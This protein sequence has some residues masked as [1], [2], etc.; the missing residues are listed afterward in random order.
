[1]IFQQLN[2][3][4]ISLVILIILGIYL[5]L[6]NLEEKVY[7]VEEVKTSLYSAGYTETE[8]SEETPVGKVLDVR[9]LENYQNLDSETSLWQTTKAITTNEPS[10]L[11]YFLTRFSM[12]TLGSEIKITRGLS[13]V[14]SLGSLPAIYW[15]SLEVF[16]ST[17][18]AEVSL[19]LVAISPFHILYSQEATEYSLLT[20]T[21]I[22]MSAVFLWAMRRPT[23]ST[24]FAY[25]GTVAVGL[26]AHPLA[27]LV[28]FGHG[29]YALFSQR[30]RLNQV[31][32]IYI[33]YA[34]LGL[35]LFMPWLFILIF[36]ENQMADW[37]LQNL[38]FPLFLQRW[39]IHIVGSVYD[40]QMGYTE[41]L[42]DI[43]NFQDISLSLTQVWVYLL[44]A[45][46]ILM[47]YS[48]YFLYRQ[49]TPA[50]WWFI[51]TL[52]GVTGLGLAVPDFVTGGQRSTISRYAIACHIGVELTLAYCLGSYLKF[53]VKNNRKN[54][55]KI[56][57]VATFTLSLISSL[58]LHN[59][60][61]WWNK[62][63]S[64]Y[65]HEVAEIINQSEQSLVVGD[66][67]RI[68]RTLSLSHDL[69]PQ[70][71]FIFFNE[72]T[73]IKLPEN[74]PDIYVFRPLQSLLDGLKTQDYSVTVR[75][76]KGKLWQ[77]ETVNSTE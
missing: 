68:A 29:I 14:I 10:P 27:G 58:V 61:T 23:P 22:L 9:F 6:T 43:E 71:Q 74:Y 28:S 53:S 56:I 20:V 25:S 11:Y 51:L 70:T 34:G 55:W 1:M 47:S 60:A 8:L 2:W 49:G 3:W 50:Q 16:A 37:M 46:F 18:I 35:I 69:K 30:W 54:L 42:F 15:L 24:W 26:Y 38:P 77:V 33:L 36:R 12:E 63:S 73:Q 66:I 32:L 52:I 40:L 31:I 65:N 76:E 39:L 59:A 75:H 41:R 44:L 17:L 67:S 72:T 13:A 57:F 45:I 7:W 19:G 64:Y 5:R 62:Y 4:R 21:I 48:F